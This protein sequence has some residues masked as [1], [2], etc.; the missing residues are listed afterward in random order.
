MQRGQRVETILRPRVAAEEEIDFED[1][2]FYEEIF[3]NDDENIVT[4]F[5]TDIFI[6]WFD[7]PDVIEGSILAF[8]SDLNPEVTN[9]SIC[10]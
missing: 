6:Y 2:P 8:F 10:F 7:Q 5:W 9:K 4:T 3:G 1:Y